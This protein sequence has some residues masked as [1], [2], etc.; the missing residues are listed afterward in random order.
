M[1]FKPL[2]YLEEE[3]KNKNIKGIRRSISSYI[4]KCLGDTEEIKD[5]IKYIEKSLTASEFASIW[6]DYD[7]LKLE[8]DKS[9]WNKTYFSSVGVDLEDNFS[10]ERFDHIL[11]VGRYVYGT[12]K[13]VTQT[14]VNESKST[15]NNT[16]T[17]KSF[18]VSKEDND[19]F[20]KI[21]LIA[22]AIIL[23]GMPLVVKMLKK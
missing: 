16:T 13:P 12:T 22:G 14:V 18:S 3:V 11:E 15:N 2:S 21:A 4:T 23:L 20:L 5:A 7:G 1:T 8:N 9:K 6:E 17:K 10:K 19:N